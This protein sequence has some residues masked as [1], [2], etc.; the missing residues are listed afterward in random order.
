MMSQFH[1]LDRV[2]S[3]KHLFNILY[4]HYF[5][6]MTL[7]RSKWWHKNRDCIITNMVIYREK[8]N[9]SHNA[10][11]MFKVSHLVAQA[12]ELTSPLQR[13]ETFRDTGKLSVIGTVEDVRTSSL[14]TKA[15]IEK[16]MQASVAHNKRPLHIYRMPLRSKRTHMV[17]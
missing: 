2:F 12:T 15:S 16:P 17:Q 5:C 8:L 4:I 9:Y 13:C 10:R 14:I 1:V 11:L 3:C 6:S 7:P